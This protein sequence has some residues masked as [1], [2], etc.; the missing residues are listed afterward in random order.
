MNGPTWRGWRWRGWIWPP[1]GI[2]LALLA[3][4]LLLME[5]HP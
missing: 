1:S 2:M 4:G 3:I 5:D